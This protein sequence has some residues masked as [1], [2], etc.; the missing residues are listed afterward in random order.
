MMTLDSTSLWQFILVFCF[1][2]KMS[3]IGFPP[4]LNSIETKLYSFHQRRFPNE[5]D[6]VH[7]FLYSLLLNLAENWKEL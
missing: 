2:L 4:L 1:L 7:S 6:A 3:G 5:K